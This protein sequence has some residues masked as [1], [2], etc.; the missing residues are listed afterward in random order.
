M[1]DPIAGTFLGFL[2]WVAYAIIA[3]SLVLWA[4]TRWP[5]SAAVKSLATAIR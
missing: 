1:S 5:N 3:G 2:Q 4:G